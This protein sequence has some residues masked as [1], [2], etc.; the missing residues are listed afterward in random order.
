MKKNKFIFVLLLLISISAV[1]FGSTFLY[2]K[3]NTDDYEPDELIVMT[4]CNPIYIATLNVV[5]DTEGVRVQNLSQPSTGCLHDYSLTTEDMKNLSYADVLVIN[6]AGMEGYLDDVIEAYPDLPV[7]DATADMDADED[8]TELAELIAENGHSWLSVL[9][10]EK[11]VTAIAEGLAAIDEENAANYLDNTEAYIKDINASLGEELS[12]LKSKLAGENLVILHEA[13]EYIAYDLDLNIVGVM[14]LDEERQVSAGE[15]ADIIDTINEND[16]KIV[17]A[18]ADYG[19]DMG[20]LIE[21]QTS[22]SVIYL[23][24]LI[25]GSYDASSYQ[26][27]MKDNYELILD[28]VFD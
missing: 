7:I 12:T 14:D 22:A 9:G 3:I 19:S 25:H 27:I 21:K 5:G 24:T 16:V 28:V 26:T 20:A 13:Y 4:S 11:E 1:A 18:E 23:N 2:V 8:N 17:F 6:G 10:F 15:V